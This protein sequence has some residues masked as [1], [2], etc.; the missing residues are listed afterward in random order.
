MK[1][2][3]IPAHQHGALHEFRA[4]LV[5]GIEAYARAVLSGCPLR[6]AV[7]RTAEWGGLRS[8]DWLP[9]GWSVKEQVMREHDPK[10]YAALPERAA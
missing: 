1:H 3:P 9:M 6:V 4:H 5:M 2:G 8:G 10:A 7:C